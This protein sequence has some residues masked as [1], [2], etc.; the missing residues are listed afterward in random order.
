M[1]FSTGCEGDVVIV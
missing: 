1:T